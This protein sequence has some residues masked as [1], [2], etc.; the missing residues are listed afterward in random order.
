[1]L[2][3]HRSERADHLI[4]PLTEVLLA[5]PEDPLAPEVIA[6][7]SRGVERWVSQQLAL[8]LGATG[9]G[10]GVA[11]N[12]EFP[13]PATLVGAVLARAAGLAPDED[14][15]VSPRLQWALLE[16]ID[17]CL[18]QPWS[19]VLAH[20]LGFGG[21]SQEQR[22]GRR[23][24]TAVLLARLFA[25]YDDNRPGMLTEWARNCDTD[26]TGKALVGDL[27]WQPA[28]WRRLRQHLGVPSPAERLDRAC[29]LVREQ[30]EVAAL[31]DR[32]SLFGPTR[33]SRTQLSVLDALAAQREVHLWLTHPSPAMWDTLAGTYP[34]MRRQ[35]DT[36]ALR[37]SNPL[38]ISLSRDFRD[39]Q[40]RL[41]TPFADVYHRS[42]SRASTVLGR[43]QDDIAHDRVAGSGGRLPHD[44]TVTI[45]A[46]HGPTRQV[47][48][49]REELLHLL[50]EDHTLQPRDI[51]VLCPD[52]ETFA[53][54]IT[55]AFA[56]LEASHPGHR[57]RVRLADRGLAQVNPLLRI[58]AALVGLADGR[59]TAGEVLDLAATAPVARRFGF[60]GADQDLL[61]QWTIDGGARWGLSQRQRQQ[62]GLAEVT[63]NTFTYAR[64]RMLLGVAADESQG[65]LGDGLALDGVDSGDVDLAGRF[66]EYLDRLDAALAR[67]GGPQSPQQWQQALHD[68]LDDLTACGD[69]DAWQRPHAARRVTEALTGSGEGEIALP[70]LRD[71][72]AGVLAPRPT[73]ANFRTGDLTVATL[74]PMRFVPHRVVAIIGLDDGCFP[75]VGHLTGDDILG[76]DPCLGERDP[77]SEDRQLLLDA[78]M[79]ATERLLICYTGADP[80]TG[81]PCPPVAP[82]A[83]VIDTVT[84]TAEEG[85][86][87]VHYQP[88]QPHDP[89]N[90]AAPEPFSYDADNYAA[91]RQMTNDTRPRPPFVPGPLP[92][93]AVCEVSL[94]DFVRFVAHPVRAFL[95]QRL[96]VSLWQADD[97]LTDALPLTLD[98]LRR[99]DIGDRLLAQIL[100]DPSG[101]AAAAFTAAELRRGSLPPGP[102]G[103]ATI[104]EI[105]ASAG[106]LARV[107]AAAA[108]AEQPRSRQITLDLGA[109]RLTGTIS[110]VYGDR[111]LSAS[112]S[113][114]KPRDRLASWVR[115]L[116]LAASGYPVSEAVTVGRI[117]GDAAVGRAAV[118]APTDPGNI[119][120]QL[121]ELRSAG[122]RYPLPMATETSFVYAKHR[123]E[124]PPTDGYRAA[125]ETWRAPEGSWGKDSEN[126]DDALVCV[127]GP[128][129]P[130]AVLWDQPAPP[131]HRW[132]DEPNWFA[133]LAIRVWGPLWELEG[134]TRVR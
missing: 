26:G 75:R 78:L 126:T 9:A 10:D 124:A 71:V 103:E 96:E 108:G 63:A 65:W 45:N 114:L 19:A 98:G 61:R 123:L 52:V 21:A 13:S 64:D 131:G 33:L 62:F 95:R 102:A 107:A 105:G 8:S 55:A 97:N 23:Y 132:F 88:L 94:D 4:G 91:A 82:L 41:P 99:W 37:L 72:L 46:C 30:R 24:A 127:Y 86:P 31:P 25:S 69:A 42:D 111:L 92:P 85:A 47:H 118:T 18:D 115:L 101:E 67:L 22:G 117:S 56:P 36:S 32:L 53:P 119:L 29:S 130:F 49:L 121:L 34:A 79:S 14:P 66:A 77:R 106:A 7:P 76:A 84:A 16:V 134:V 1:M 39:L 113:T 5:T 68:A 87:V 128:D 125:A 89:V 6:V 104:A 54:L 17:S 51:I 11:A 129:A 20:H 80:V 38:L 100:A 122:L 44:N 48:V 81:Q 28:L 109:V 57:I 74:V 43:I 83:E 90:F 120:T 70:D 93:V 73:R 58:A 2:I 40:Q 110:G 35:E 12:I 59:V 15:W 50:A 60:T 27:C 3:V 112:Y 133:Q 116:A